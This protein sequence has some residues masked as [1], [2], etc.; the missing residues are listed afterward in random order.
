MNTKKRILLAED[1]KEL[2]KAVKTIL[3]YS[4]YDVEVVYNGQD[5]VNN[6][7]N[8]NFDVVIMD[9]M[10]PVMD[11]IEAVKEMRKIGVKTPVI[12]L[13]AK[14]QI[15]DKVEGLDAGAN[16]YLTK[17]FD[18]KELL[19]RIRAQIRV[20]EEKE[21][22]Y[23]IGNISFNKETSELSNDKAIFHLNNKEC[24]ILEILVKNQESAI[25]ASELGKIIWQSEE[26]ATNNLP[27]YISYLQNK[28]IALE[29]SVMINDKNGYILESKV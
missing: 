1:E 7:K 6:V 27:M 2:A 5:V 18:K 26:S 20:N 14:S 24:D 12:L 22:R 3:N 28:F 10:M 13:T 4:N 9:I 25:S 16:D 29:S 11:G 8:N 15:D 23:N 19:A 17:P 21:Q